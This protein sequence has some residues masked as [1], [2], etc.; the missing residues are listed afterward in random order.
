MARKPPSLNS[1]KRTKWNGFRSR[2]VSMMNDSHASALSTSPSTGFLFCSIFVDH[3]R[4][5]WMISSREFGALCFDTR[6]PR[7]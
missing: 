2:R 3:R 4:G 7:H 5:R 1:G 6:F